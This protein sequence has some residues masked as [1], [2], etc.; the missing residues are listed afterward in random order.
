MIDFFNS[1]SSLELRELKIE[2]RYELVL[3]INK[4][5]L[6]NMYRNTTETKFT[7]VK[8]AIIKFNNDFD[9]ITRASFPS[10]WD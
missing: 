4:M 2:D 10:C 8:E 5:V 9:K 7:E 1:K 6:K 3:E